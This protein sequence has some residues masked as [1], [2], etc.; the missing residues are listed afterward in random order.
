MLPARITAHNTACARFAGEVGK[1]PIQEAQSNAFAVRR[2]TLAHIDF[3][4]FDI[5]PFL[6]LN[7][8][9]VVP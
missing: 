9:T 8:G 6:L 7:S 5:R 2:T 3:S 1:P 4:I